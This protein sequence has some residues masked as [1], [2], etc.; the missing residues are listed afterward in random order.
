M[1]HGHDEA[2]GGQPGS[3]APPPL[4]LDHV[5]VPVHDV[6]GALAFYGGTLGLPLLDALSG[7]DWGGQPW[8]MMIFGL[9]DGGRHL[10]VSAF[11]HVDAPVGSPFPR[12][13]R[14]HAFAVD[15]VFAWTSW[16]ERLQQANVT[17]WEEDHGSQRSLYVVDPSGNVFEITTP[18]TPTADERRGQAVIEAWLRGKSL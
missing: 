9:G 12:D 1:T 16:R 18:P 2:T 15:T 11:R 5:V 6:A 8:I 3:L 7:D 13:A 17:F 4:R 10:A 14:H